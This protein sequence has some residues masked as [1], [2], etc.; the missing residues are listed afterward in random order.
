M[1]RRYRYQDVRLTEYLAA[2]DR[3]RTTR[4]SCVHQSGVPTGPLTDVA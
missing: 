3:Y 4:Q 1:Y 2:R